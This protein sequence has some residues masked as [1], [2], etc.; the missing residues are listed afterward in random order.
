MDFV[1]VNSHYA[2][3]AT[4]NLSSRTKNW[5]K[6]LQPIIIKGIFQVKTFH[7]NKGHADVTHHL[8]KTKK[9]RIQMLW[10][11]LCQSR[12]VHVR[13][14]QS[15]EQ[16]PVGLMKDPVSLRGGW[17]QFWHLSTGAPFPEWPNILNWTT[18]SGLENE[19]G[20]RC[21]PSPWFIALGCWVPGQRHTHIQMQGINSQMHLQL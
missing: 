19:G 5:T 15:S 9:E 10:T 16:R 2:W 14:Q 8:S 12:S 6:K 1:T 18:A 11:R 4:Q 17:L 13:A 7:T 21:R 3:D 20:H